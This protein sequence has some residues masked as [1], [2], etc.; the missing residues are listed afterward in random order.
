MAR[1]VSGI[2]GSGRPL[3]V[4]A[5]L[6]SFGL[7]ALGQA[8]RRAA[9]VPPV[10]ETSMSGNMEPAKAL[11][12]IV[13][14]AP[15]EQTKKWLE[16]KPKQDVTNPAIRKLF[17]ALEAAGESRV[18][19][20]LSM[21][22]YV[23]ALSLGRDTAQPA[24]AAERGLGLMLDCL[25]DFKGA[26]D[27]LSGGNLAVFTPDILRVVDNYA[28][29]KGTSGRTVAELASLTPEQLRAFETQ[30]TDTAR[31]FSQALEALRYYVAT[32]YNLQQVITVNGKR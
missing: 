22:N 3:I 11:L 25:Q 29:A 12:A 23:R 17:S 4:I 26:V 5:A 8:P 21:R 2:S 9:S 27:I 31:K 10:A 6:A 14:P 30:L 16:S 28:H 32:N 13:V 24:S 7:Q 15:L 19:Y 20:V 18:V 1:M